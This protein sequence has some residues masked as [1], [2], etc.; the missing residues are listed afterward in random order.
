[1]RTAL[2]KSLMDRQAAR[3]GAEVFGRSSHDDV[4]HELWIVE[5]GDERDALT[6]ALSGIDVFIADGHHRYTTA[7][8]YKLEL[9][10]LQG[11]LPGNHPANY[12]LFVLVAG[13]D[14]GMVILP[15]HRVLGNMPW[16]TFERFEQLAE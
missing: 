11:P 10:A 6:S 5:D 3:R 15:T 1:E 7:L 16:F 12:A 2:V 9:E 8:N 4:L 13:D 14:P